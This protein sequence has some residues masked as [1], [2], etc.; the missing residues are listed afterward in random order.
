MDNEKK[1]FYIEELNKYRQKH[2]VELKYHELSRSGPPHE[3]TFTFKVTINGRE[4]PKAEGKSKQEAKNAAAKVAVETLNKENK[5]VGSVPLE[6][7]DPSEGLYLGNY[8]GLL[9][10]LAQKERL[11]VNYEPCKLSKREPGRFYYKCKI[12]E[13][14]YGTG[15]G[16]TK[17][18]AKQL[19]AKLAYDQL[20][21]TNPT[22]PGSSVTTST[23]FRSARSEAPMS[24]FNSPLG[25]C[26]SAT[27]PG[28]QQ[29]QNGLNGSPSSS[30]VNARSNEIKEKRNLAPTVDS[31]DKEAT[32]YTADDR[33]TKD[34]KEIEPIGSGGFGRIFKAKHRIDGKVYAIKRVKYDN[35][36][37]A[38]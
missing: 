28:K 10:R 36:F 16:S 3:Q 14:E 12:E 30:P 21:A 37:Y 29:D 5:E 20:M 26:H 35:E 34:F 2:N 25:N 11:N 17:Q 1:G 23:D 38:P 27:V 32:K 13:K 8:I 7:V 33:F 31:L 15:I 22:S 9:N 19:A 6:A 4:F 18:E 24:T